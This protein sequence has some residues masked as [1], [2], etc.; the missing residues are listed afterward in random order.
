MNA[1]ITQQME[2]EKIEQKRETER[3]KLLEEL[4]KDEERLSARKAERD[5]E[6]I[7]LK[8][9]HEQQLAELKSREIETEKLRKDET[10]LRECEK[11]LKIELTNLNLHVIQR[12]ER[13]HV[14]HNLR[15]I[16][17][18]LKNLSESVL[19]DLMYD[20]GVLER[21]SSYYHTDD[22]QIA[23]VRTKFEI[24]CDL[25][26]QKQHHIEAMYESEAKMFV[27]KQQETWLKESDEREKILSDLIK[28]QIDQISNEINFIESRQRELG[29]LRD[30]LRRSIDS[31]N[32]RIQSLVGA[33]INDEEQRI[34]SADLI[35]KS[36]TPVQSIP[37]TAREDL[38]SEICL[39]DLFSKA[40]SVS[41]AN[42]S[43]ISTGR[44]RFGRKKIAWT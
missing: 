27:L 25:E 15:R 39:P 11:R 1:Q 28:D 42:D 33:N 22:Q 26:R 41:D 24:Q 29:E 21:L 6:V 23:C 13:I 5:E 16:K 14:S 20:I 8:Q 12:H 9:F 31:T 44:P 37:N 18:Q 19:K 40:L 3:V 10:E 35:R 17:L 30:C 36:T 7:Q 2:R 43:P 4:R 32:D 38:Q 34:R